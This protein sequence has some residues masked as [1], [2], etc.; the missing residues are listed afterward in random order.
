MGPGQTAISSSKQSL[1]VSILSAGTFFGSL[2][3]GDL[4][5]KIGRRPTI[6]AG[7][8]LDFYPPHF[9]PS[10]LLLSRFFLLTLRFSSR[11]LPLHGRSCHADVRRYRPCHYCRR[12]YCRYVVSPSAPLFPILAETDPS[13]FAAGL[14][15]GFVSAIIILY[16]S[17]IC[18]RKVR[19]ALVAGYQFAITIGI[20]LAS[21]VCNFTQTREDDSAYRI[22]IGLQCVAFFLIFLSIFPF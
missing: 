20:M 22:P 11:M 1:I 19:G 15:V 6:I 10:S 5:D 3:A 16:M 17:E 18:P 9:P 8:S 2:I 21:I 4:S 12:S 7:A 14:G 13:L